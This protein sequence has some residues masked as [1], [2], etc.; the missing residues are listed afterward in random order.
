[1]KAITLLPVVMVVTLGLAGCSSIFG[2]GKSSIASARSSNVEDIYRDY[3]ADQLELGRGMIQQGAY[4][5]ALEALRRASFHPATAAAAHNAMGVVYAK[6]GRKDIAERM[7]RLAINENPGD[8][9]FASNLERLEATGAI[10]HSPKADSAMPAQ[11]GNVGTMPLAALVPAN[12]AGDAPIRAA[13]VV[14][15]LRIMR[16]AYGAALEVSQ[17]AGPIQRLSQYEVK[18]GG[19]A[20]PT[21]SAPVRQAYAGELL[22]FP[23]RSRIEVSSPP[24]QGAARTVHAY[25]ARI[26]F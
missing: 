1:M 24:T 5:A 6:L 10:A 11:A 8:P 13:Q 20:T 19:A 7:F 15:A 9:K 17:P 12:S 3:A 23:Q 18:V 2:H 21:R 26:I 4:T 14:Q 16:P 22:G 25:P